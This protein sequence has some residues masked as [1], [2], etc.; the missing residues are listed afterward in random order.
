MTSCR[1]AASGG[2][3]RTRPSARAPPPARRRRCRRPDR[4]SPRPA[5]GPRPCRPAG[6][7]GPPRAG[8][9]RPARARPRDQR[10]KQC[11]QA[12]GKQAAH[13]RASRPIRVTS[14]TAPISLPAILHNRNIASLQSRQPWGRPHMFTAATARRVVTIVLLAGLS[15]TISSGARPSAVRP[16]P[17][18]L[19]EGELRRLPQ[20]ARRRRRRLWRRGVV[21]ARDHARARRPDRGD[22]LRPAGD[23]HHPRD[24]S[25]SWTGRTGSLV[26]P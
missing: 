14:S 19:R 20:V 16:W 5:A 23:G 24:A 2:S 8:P 17:A 3:G 9:R 26:L 13:H 10:A 11:S 4:R 6:R 7:A 1:P 12:H 21:A 18:R 15:V 25:A 22:P